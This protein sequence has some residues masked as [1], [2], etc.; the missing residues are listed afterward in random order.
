M[1]GVGD[2]ELVVGDGTDQSGRK[3]RP[4]LEHQNKD[5][6]QVNVFP[7]RTALLSPLRWL[8]DGP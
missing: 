8:Q 1:G 7:P 5:G 4:G 6:I 3:K 2:R